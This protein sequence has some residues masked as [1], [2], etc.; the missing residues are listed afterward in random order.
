MVD[1][2]SEI[3]SAAGWKLKTLLRTRRFYVD[4]DLVVFY[5][6]HLLGYLEYRTPAVYHSTRSV[7]CRLDAV[8]TRFLKDIGIDE[9]TALLR[10]HLA[11]LSA[12]RDMALLGLIH[13]TVLGKGPEQF[14]VFFKLEDQSMALQDPRKTTFDQE[15]YVWVDSHLQHASSKNSFCRVSACFPKGLARFHDYICRSWVSSVV[16]GSVSTPPSVYTSSRDI[17]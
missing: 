17:S 7:L 4:A 14:R 12:R 6:S 16:R 5:K 8:Q 3:V 15:V 13:R 2:V 9:Q 11:P 10:F 1:A